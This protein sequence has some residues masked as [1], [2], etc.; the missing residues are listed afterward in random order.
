MT[1]LE[2]A[3][4]FLRDKRNHINRGS[5]A[6]VHRTIRYRWPTVTLLAAYRA[7]SRPA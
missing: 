2:K 3:V 4:A 6:L 1:D 5:A 7:A